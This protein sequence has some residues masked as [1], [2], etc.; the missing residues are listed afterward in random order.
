MSKKQ[1]LS[2]FIIFFSTSNSFTS[3]YFAIEGTTGAGKSTFLRLFASHINDLHIVDEQID[4]ILDVGGT[5]NLLD[6]FYKDHERWAYLFQTYIFMVRDKAIN[7]ALQMDPGKTILGDRSI[8]STF[9]VFGKMLNEKNLFQEMEWYIYQQW[10][11]YSLERTMTKPKGFI[12]L[13]TTPEVCYERVKKRNRSEEQGAPYDYYKSEF[14]FHEKWLRDK[15]VDYAWLKDVPVL[16]LDGN[17]DFL[18]N[19]QVLISMIDQIKNFIAQITV[20]NNA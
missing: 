4:K 2:I 16:I 19:E 5:G 9:Y 20:Q 3:Y 11:T 13:R 7:Q 15:N 18:Y 8:Y 10:I 17:Q 12:Y 14:D 1:F 6:L